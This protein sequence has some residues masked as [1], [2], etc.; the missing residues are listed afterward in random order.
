MNH[1]RRDEANENALPVPDSSRTAQP[2]RLSVLFAPTDIAI[3]CY[4]R[5]LFG[6]V[7]AWH[8][9]RYVS[10][11]WVDHFY[12]IPKFH[13]TYYFFDWVRPWPG[14]GM[15]I[16]FYVMGAAA[17]GIILGLFYR[18][19]AIIF[20]CS[21]TYIFLVESAWYQ[22]HYYLVCLL[23]LIMIF[24]PANRRFSMDVALQLT[25]PSDHAPAWMLWMLRL[26]I[27]IAYFYGGV[28]K[29]KF[30]WL[31]GEPMR[32]LLASKGDY[33]VL[34]P[35]FQEEWMGQ[36]FTWGGLLFDLAVV[37]MLLW[38]RTRLLAFAATT[39]FH[40]M[41]TTLWHIDFFPW[42]MLFAA[43]IYFPPDWPR[44]LFRWPAASAPLKPTPSG[45]LSTG[46]KGTAALLGI[47]LAIQILVPFRHHL[48]PSNVLWSKEGHFFS[49]HMITYTMRAGVRFEARDPRT[50]NTWEVDF[51]KYLNER[52]AIHLGR[53]PNKI[54]QFSHF[55]ADEYRKRGLKDIEIRA[56]A[57]VSLN[58]RK[59][60]LVVDPTMNLADQPRTLKSQPYVLPLLEPLRRKHWDLPISQWEAALN[61][62]R[63]QETSP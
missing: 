21:F 31:Q 62:Q 45:A 41:N 61:A 4:F 53:D 16:Q 32:L 9:W 11:G 59:P 36:L 38:R 28:A 57:L 46:Q 55:A 51:E 63:E 40:L 17:I 42:F 26:Q 33:P 49:W 6:I 2:S 52:Q 13:Y 39:G 27:G 37:P 20:F 3:L 19:S 25:R 30:D 47:Y 22:N 60:Q 58:G 23:S 50:G 10:Q 1:S 48:Y 24:V 56:Y 12:V 14:M 43:L 35:Y 29:F 8:V 54:L 34:G 5:V 18:L 7:M 15:H 44:K